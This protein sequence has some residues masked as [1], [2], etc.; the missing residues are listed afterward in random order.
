[1]T[2]TL[3]TIVS[4]RTQQSIPDHR[5]TQ[6]LVIDKIF[7]GGNKIGLDELMRLEQTLKTGEG[8]LL[9][10]KEQVAEEVFDFYSGFLLASLRRDL[11]NHESRILHNYI[12]PQDFDLLPNLRTASH[13][14]YETAALKL[15]EQMPSFL[16]SICSKTILAGLEFVLEDHFSKSPHLTT[17]SSYN[18]WGKMSIRECRHLTQTLELRGVP[19]EPGHRIA[20]DLSS[21]RGTLVCEEAAAVWLLPWYD[22]AVISDG[23]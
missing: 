6:K 23:L 5:P 17:I 9:L 21:R 22:V 8:R 20:V 7:A 1:M 10:S 3:D 4:Y 18:P 12:E 19:S 14:E 13:Q 16:S 11:A 2:N 15:V